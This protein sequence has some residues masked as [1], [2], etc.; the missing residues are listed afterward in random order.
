MSNLARPAGEPERTSNAATAPMPLVVY[1][2]PDLN[3]WVRDRGGACSPPRNL[4]GNRGQLGWIGMKPLCQIGRV[5]KSPLR[6]LNASSIA[7]S[8][9]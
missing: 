8:C 3:A 9:R 1:L 7:A 4:I 6:C 2:V 5:A